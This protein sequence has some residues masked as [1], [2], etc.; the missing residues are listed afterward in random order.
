MIFNLR[1]IKWVNRAVERDKLKLKK[2]KISSKSKIMPL[3]KAKK[4]IKVCKEV[5][6]KSKNTQMIIINNLIRTT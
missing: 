1:K 3:K 2:G 5:K 4:L 6:F